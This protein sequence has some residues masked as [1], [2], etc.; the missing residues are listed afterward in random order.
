VG[1]LNVTSGYQYADHEEEVDWVPVRWWSMGI[2][3]EMKTDSLSKSTTSPF[4]TRSS[5]QSLAHPSHNLTPHPSPPPLG[6]YPRAMMGAVTTHPPIQSVPSSPL[7]FSTFLCRRT[8]VSTLSIHT[9]K[10]TVSGAERRVKSVGREESLER[11]IDH[12][13]KFRR[14]D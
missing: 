9:I 11:G 8:G 3:E 4:L 7:C 13:G 2:I 14:E 6:S 12:L 5:P 10:E 1:G